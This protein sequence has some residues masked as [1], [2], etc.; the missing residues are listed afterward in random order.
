MSRSVPLALCCVLA[1]GGSSALFQHSPA[2]SP[3][4]GHQM[5]FDE[6]RGQVLLF[7]GE[8]GVAARARLSDTWAWNGARWTRLAVNGPGR[9]D[10]LMVYD[11]ARQRTVLFGGSGPNGSNLADTW[12]WNGTEWKLAASEGPGV[13]VH[14]VMAYDAA[15]RRV[16]LQGGADGVTWRTDTWEW[17][18]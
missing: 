3:R 16:V 6:A 17:D 5:V 14:P 9:M 18:G 11:A 12:E 15:R 1:G 13:R 10:A 8:S 4:F 7:G 2:P